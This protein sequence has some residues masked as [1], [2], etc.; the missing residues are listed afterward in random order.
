MNVSLLTKWLLKLE[1]QAKIITGALKE[2]PKFSGMFSCP[3]Y[4]VFF[5]FHNFLYT[6]LQIK[7]RIN[8]YVPF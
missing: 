6:R 8:I 4:R 2:H 3:K 1:G 7:H 5:L